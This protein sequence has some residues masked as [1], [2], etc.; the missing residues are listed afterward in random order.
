VLKEQFCA[1]LEPL[2]TCHA[3]AA[4][5]LI[6]RDYHAENLL[7]LPE[8]AGLARVGLLDF[9]D[10]LEG[11]RAYDLVSLLQD[12]R[13][14]VSNRVESAMLE[15]YIAATG[16]DAESFITAYRLLGAQRNLRILG[17]FARLCLRDS[18]PRYLDLIPRVWA[19]L[20]R[21]LEH[22]ALSP[23]RPILADAL[24][25]PTPSILAR[26][27]DQCAIIPTLS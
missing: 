2:L 3:A 16:Q 6:L 8:R 4:D 10:A 18:K 23:L 15:R 21:D 19:Y 7:W 9:Q 20:Q 12:A 24:P 22:P 27:K 25:A 26:L 14:D 13:R 11:H 17:V 5:V 1:V